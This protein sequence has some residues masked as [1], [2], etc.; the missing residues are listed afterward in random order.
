MPHDDNMGKD[1][2]S[3]KRRVLEI[4]AESVKGD[5]DQRIVAQA[6][7]TAWLTQTH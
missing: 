5:I 4:P 1:R 2:Q 7:V 3:P 6:V